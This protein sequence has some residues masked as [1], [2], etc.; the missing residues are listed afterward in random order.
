MVWHCNELPSLQRFL[1]H[2]RN[3]VAHY[4]FELNHSQ[5]RIESIHFYD[6]R[7]KNSA[8]D[9]E[10]TIGFTQLKQLAKRLARFILT[11]AFEQSVAS[12]IRDIA[13][14]LAGITTN[15]QWTQAYK[16]AIVSLSRSYDTELRFHPT[17]VSA[18]NA[19]TSSDPF[20]VLARV[21]WQPFHVAASEL[22]VPIEPQPDLRILVFDAR[23][24]R[25]ARFDT[26]KSLIETQFVDDSG[27]RYLLI[28]HEGSS[29][30]GVKSH[31]WFS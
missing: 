28:A 14:S 24:R 6:Q 22:T 4:R 31:A 9:W 26:E 3:S 8:R 10:C 16:D 25:Y 2:L 30:S 1:I 15:T 21:N 29:R 20:R 17:E 27:Q 19:S 7:P 13:P 12:A 5:G 11:V 23:I 18:A